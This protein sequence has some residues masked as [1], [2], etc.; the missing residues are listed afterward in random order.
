MSRLIKK[1][2]RHLLIRRALH[3][4]REQM[5]RQTW[6]P[7]TPSQLF[8][9]AASRKGRLVQ[10]DGQ[11]VEVIL[12]SI[13]RFQTKLQ[14]K[15]PLARLLWAGDR[16]KPEEDLSDWLEVQFNED[17][18]GQGIVIGREV[19]IHHLS[20]LDLCIDAVAKDPGHE[21]YST[22]QVIIEVKGC[23]HR[24]LKNAMKPSFSIATW[25]KTTASRAFILSVGSCATHGPARTH[26][27]TPSSFAPWRERISFW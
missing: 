20:R 11:S 7:P 8:E 27:A 26:L 5:R 16:P 21:N 4:A 14:G 13:A 10:S 3:Q 17:L 24:E 12:E 22:V 2:P 18:T 1:F 6:Q 19:K 9:L 15:R 23:W 25:Q